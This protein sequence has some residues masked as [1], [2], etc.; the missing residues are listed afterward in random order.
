ML[1]GSF[2]RGTR[3]ERLSYWPPNADAGA[4]ANPP[5]GGATPRVGTSAA[6]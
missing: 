4:A 1:I 2:A 6:P 5:G 3:D